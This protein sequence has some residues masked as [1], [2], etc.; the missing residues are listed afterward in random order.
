M[1]LWFFW[2]LYL[3]IFLLWFKYK[4]KILLCCCFYSYVKIFDPLYSYFFHI[5]FHYFNFS[6]MFFLVVNICWALKGIINIKP[7]LWYKN[8]IVKIHVFIAFVVLNLFIVISKR[9]KKKE[10]G[11]PRWICSHSPLFAKHVCATIFSQNMQFQ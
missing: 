6:T 10:K 2:D 11:K 4:K 3:V 9:K 7:Y 8:Y 1:F 5:F